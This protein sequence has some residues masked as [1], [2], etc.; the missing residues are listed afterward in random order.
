MA[1][2]TLPE[3]GPIIYCPSDVWFL[4][5]LLKSKGLIDKEDIYAWCARSVAR[6]V[7]FW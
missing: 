1:E 4:L 2:L 3:V 7:I 5:E 6:L